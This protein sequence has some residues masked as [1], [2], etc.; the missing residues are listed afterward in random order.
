[1]ISA[2]ILTHKLLAAMAKKGWNL[3]DTC[4]NCGLDNRTLNKILAGEMPARIDAFYRL[5]RGLGVEVEDVLHSVQPHE[6]R[7]AE[8][9]LLR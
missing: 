2:I 4:V 5:C 6:K 7:R 3:R 9:R 1:M 8:I